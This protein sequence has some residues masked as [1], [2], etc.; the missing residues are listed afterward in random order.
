MAGML[1][2]NIQI[3]FTIIKIII[4]RILLVIG[5]RCHSRC[6]YTRTSNTA[7]H[8]YH[9]KSIAW[10]S[11]GMVLRLGTLPVAGASLMR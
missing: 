8:D 4:I 1:G 3:P 2:T 9:E 5:R 6:A 11:I 10:L 7:S